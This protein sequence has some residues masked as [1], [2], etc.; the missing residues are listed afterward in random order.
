M[1]RTPQRRRP[2]RRQQRRPTR[3]PCHAA[4]RR[5]PTQPASHRRPPRRSHAQS[6]TDRH[7]TPPRR[8]HRSTLLAQ[9]ARKESDFRIRRSDMQSPREAVRGTGRSTRLVQRNGGTERAS[10]P[11]LDTVLG[12][13]GLLTVPAHRSRPIEGSA[14][15]DAWSQTTP[16]STGNRRRA[17]LCSNLPRGHYE[18]G[19]DANP[20]HRLQQSSSNSPSLSDRAPTSVSLLPSINVPSINALCHSGR[21]NQYILC[22]GILLTVQVRQARSARRRG[23]VCFCVAGHL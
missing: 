19:P 6:V 23:D 14:A 8:H 11:T 2:G 9:H 7:E 15:T 12:P 5:I 22:R 10:D 20:G 17:R 3:T 4:R 13:T 16:L 21:S 18:P 1:R